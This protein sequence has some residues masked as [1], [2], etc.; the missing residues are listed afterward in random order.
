MNEYK[1]DLLSNGLTKRYLVLS[2]GS[3][4]F[5]PVGLLTK[6]NNT[7]TEQ[8]PWTILSGVGG[9]QTL[10]GHLWG[11]KREALNVLKSVLEVGE[12][13]CKSML[14][15][16]NEGNGASTIGFD[17]DVKTCQVMGCVEA[18]RVIERRGGWAIE[19]KS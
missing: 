10:V 15:A 3:C 4:L 7:R 1:T 8:F 2:K 12:D 16:H 9:R 17:Y 5:Y 11:T 13:K 6:I 19:I 14:E 18:G